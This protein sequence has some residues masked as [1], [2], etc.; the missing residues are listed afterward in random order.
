MRYVQ[1][2]QYIG[3]IISCQRS[4]VFIVNF[5]QISHIA[6]V[7]PFADFEQENVCWVVGCTF[8]RI[9]SLEMAASYISKDIY[10]GD[11]LRLTLISIK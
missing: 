7:L 1:S 4:R 2:W 9:Y 3:I 8:L 10:K 6:K 5:E 11:I